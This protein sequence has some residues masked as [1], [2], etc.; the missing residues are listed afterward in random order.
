MTRKYDSDAMV[1]LEIGNKYPYDAT[2]E[3]WCSD[4][5]AKPPQ[6]W[7]HF[8]ARGIISNL[9][10][11][12]KIGRGFDDIDEDVRQEI[13]ETIADIIRLAYEMEMAKNET[14]E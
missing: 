8:A 2:D 7:A 5:K 11:R 4:D 6:D 9:K 12:R 10:D 13:V 14:S 1:D 3:W